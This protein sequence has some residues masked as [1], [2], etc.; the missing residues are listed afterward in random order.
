[1]VL[2]L[3]TTLLL[4]KM[5]ILLS[6]TMETQ[7]MKELLKERVLLLS[8]PM[9][10]TQMAIRLLTVAMRLLT[11]VMGSQTATK[12]YL[13]ITLIMLLILLTKLPILPSFSMEKS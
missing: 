11:V 12:M 9:V 7:L 13:T 1:M 10:M 4:S 3:S 8:F 2:S 6:M 5:E